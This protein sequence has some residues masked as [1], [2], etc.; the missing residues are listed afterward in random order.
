MDDP[1]SP[2]VE[3]LVGVAY[4]EGGRAPRT[5]LDCWGVVIE[6]CRRL[7]L[8]IPDPF[9]GQTDYS[10]SKAQAKGYSVGIFTDMTRWRPLQYHEQTRGSVIAFRN[11][12][13]YVD[14][15]GVVLDTTRFLHAL[16]DS[17]VIISRRTDEP[18]CRCVAG[19]YGYL[20]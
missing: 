1:R 14:H 17:G 4:A 12:H 9:I 20:V 2:S 16:R 5:G 18:W 7:G 10:V 8:A 11:P 13:G 19:V 15:A 3:D 6:A